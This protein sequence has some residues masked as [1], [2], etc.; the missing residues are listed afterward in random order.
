MCNNQTLNIFCCRSELLQSAA[1][2]LAKSMPNAA[3][4][5]TAS[6]PL[7][8]NPPQPEKDSTNMGSTA[9]DLTKT[10][11]K[12]KPAPSMERLL[13]DDDDEE[14]QS[15]PDLPASNK[16]TSEVPRFGSSMSL[17]DMLDFNAEDEDSQSQ[18]DHQPSNTE[19]PQ[20]P[21]ENGNIE[22]NTNTDSINLNSNNTEVSDTGNRRGMS[23]DEL[24][25]DIMSSPGPNLPTAKDLLGDID[26]GNKYKES[27]TQSVPD[28]T[29]T[30]TSRTVKDGTNSYKDSTSGYKDST[31]G[32]GTNPLEHLASIA[33]SGPSNMGGGIMNPS[34]MGAA[35]MNPMNNPW[36]SLF[37]SSPPSASNM[38]IPPY[39]PPP[40]YPY[41]PPPYP[42]MPPA[43]TGAPPNPWGYTP[44]PPMY[45]PPGYGMPHGLAPPQQGTAN[46][47]TTH[48]SHDKSQSNPDS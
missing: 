44:P 41:Y 31:S 37:G 30:E 29:V 42:Y 4:M 33:N 12:K 17:S 27:N 25:D 23:F 46:Q 43:P 32:Y 34:S 1:A 9:L 7:A 40:M 2:L 6:Q 16:P 18:M 14:E 38:N 39:P 26:D 28:T 15:K 22:S 19:L 10:T 21:K 36:A 20:L 47:N 24:F 48:S 13:A 45:M 3:S 5:L 11:P 8:A 35:A